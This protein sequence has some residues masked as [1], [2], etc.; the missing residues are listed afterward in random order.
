MWQT[1]RYPFSTDPVLGFEDSSN[2]DIV[3]AHRQVKRVC[4]GIQGEPLPSQT[5][6]DLSSGRGRLESEFLDFLTTPTKF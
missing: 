2:L 4:T 5:A 6:Y 3:G 1:D